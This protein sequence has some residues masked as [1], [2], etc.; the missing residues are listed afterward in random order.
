MAGLRTWA[1][2]RLLI[3]RKEKSS[4]EKNL[5]IPGNSQSKIQRQVEY[6][7]SSKQPS[8]INSGPTLP[9]LDDLGLPPVTG[10]LGCS[11]EGVG[12][13]CEAFAIASTWLARVLKRLPQDGTFNQ[14]KTLVGKPFSYDLSSATD[15]WPLANHL[16]ITFV[17]HCLHSKTYYGVVVSTTVLGDELVIADA[18][19]ASVYASVLGSLNIE[20]KI[21]N[22][23]HGRRCRVLLQDRDSSWQRHI[24]VHDLKRLMFTARFAFGLSSQVVAAT[25]MLAYLRDNNIRFSVVIAVT[26]LA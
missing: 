10:H 17:G 6:L 11:L 12:K 23:Q 15:R 9:F 13:R 8:L 14:I 20:M 3:G 26:I 19:V 1:L 25:I 21:L 24:D 5:S 18:K 22:I 7:A 2:E 4:A 16:I